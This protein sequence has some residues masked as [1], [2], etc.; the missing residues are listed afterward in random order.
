MKQLLS[1]KLRLFITCLTLSVSSFYAQAKD[2]LTLRYTA[3]AGVIIASGPSRVLV[4]TFFSRT[5]GRFHA[6]DREGHKR[7]YSQQIPLALATHIHGDHFTSG[8]VIGYLNSNPSTTFAGSEQVVTQ[9]RGKVK[10]KQLVSAKLGPAEKMSF[11]KNGMTVSMLNM[12]HGDGQFATIQNYAQYIDINGWKVLHVGD[13]A[14]DLD[15]TAKL[16]FDELQID[17][18]IVPYWYLFTEGGKEQMEL[19]GADNWVFVHMP[20]EDIDRFD[21]ALK[22][23]RSD[24]ETL[25]LKNKTVKYSREI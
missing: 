3:N 25:S 9:L 17:V 22:K 14:I 21:Q 15:N 4:D 6:L 23:K 19:I 1:R 12:P 5:F 11:E 10:D 13:A 20:E 16:G 2:E 8:P 18:A 7:I 24:A